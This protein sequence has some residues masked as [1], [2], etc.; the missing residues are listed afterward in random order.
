MGFEF[1]FLA[2]VVAVPTPTLT[3]TV[4]HLSLLS[5]FWGFETISAGPSHF[6]L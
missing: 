1:G 2:A 5:V 4:L 3:F 6:C